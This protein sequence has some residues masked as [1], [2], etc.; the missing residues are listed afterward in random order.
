MSGVE[1]AVARLVEW[2][3]SGTGRKMARYGVAS[4]VSVVVGQAL[5]V[6][7]Y[8]V[9][10]WDARAANVLAGV[11]AGIPSFYLNRLWVW[12]KRGRSHLLYEVAPFWA[13]AFLG[14]GLSTWLVGVTDTWA[15]KAT[16]DQVL[17]TMAVA[18]SSMA[19]VGV[20]WVGKYLAFNRIFQATPAQTPGDRP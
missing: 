3:A 2:T 16:S 7:L 20:V 1:R 18:G 6:I 4:T 15:R 12:G 13:L 14:L 17:R 9:V 5:L 10:G 11:G 19:A 8:G